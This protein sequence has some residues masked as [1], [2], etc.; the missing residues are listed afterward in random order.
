MEEELEEIKKKTEAAAEQLSVV[1]DPRKQPYLVNPKL[2]DS[3]EGKP[4]KIDELV[5]TPTKDESP[6]ANQ[7]R[8]ELL[9]QTPDSRYPETPRASELDVFDNTMTPS[10]FLPM[11]LQTEPRKHGGESVK[12]TP[13]E[14]GRPP[15]KPPA[16]A[17]S[18]GNTGRGTVDN[19]A[20]VTD[21]STHRH[22]YNTGGQP[23]LSS[24]NSPVIIF[25]ES[26]SHSAAF[27][28]KNLSGSILATPSSVQSEDSQDSWLKAANMPDSPWKD[29][30]SPEQIISSV[31]DYDRSASRL[32]TPGIAS[33]A[34]HASALYQRRERVPDSDDDSIISE[35]PTP[36][37]PPLSSTRNNSVRATAVGN[38]LAGLKSPLVMSS[39]SAKSHKPVISGPVHNIVAQ[40]PIVARSFSLAEEDYKDPSLLQPAIS[41]AKIASDRPETIDEISETMILS[42]E[43]KIGYDQSNTNKIEGIQSPEKPVA[44]VQLKQVLL[45]GDISHIKRMIFSEDNKLRPV[46]P[47]LTPEVASRLLFDCC[48]DTTRMKDPEG[49][50]LIIVKE[51]GADVNFLDADGKSVLFSLLLTPELAKTIIRLG[52]DVLKCDSRGLC[53]LSVC[54]DLSS[55]GIID[56]DWIIEYFEESKQFESLPSIVILDYFRI[57]TIA[58]RCSAASR[59]LESGRITVSPE[60]ASQIMKSCNFESLSESMEIYEMLEKIGGQLFSEV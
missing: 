1:V 11:T 5:L 55:Q 2:I 20:S 4:W 39:Y 40:S 26:M 32:I 24:V 34:P 36:Q 10:S 44:I 3:P 58:G 17:V 59:L 56:G 13:H 31:P 45:G 27:G 51:L 18:I 30:P 19:L 57:L 53:P 38:N 7:W 28:N 46:D 52:A 21:S 42:M 25:P 50:L 23:K 47:P 16:S 43:E 41:T 35:I 9:G 29:V 6:D 8:S 49:T 14:A 54:L 37:K 12:Q 22:Y 33:V 48:V 60:E 15:Q